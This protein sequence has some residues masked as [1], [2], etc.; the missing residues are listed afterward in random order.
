MRILVVVVS[1]LSETPNHQVT[2]GFITPISH[3]ITSWFNVVIDRGQYGRSDQ[4]AAT[5]CVLTPVSH[6][7]GDVHIVAD[8]YNYENVSDDHLTVE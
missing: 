1:A 8:V 2:Y 4:S 7:P 3:N 6:P 5:L